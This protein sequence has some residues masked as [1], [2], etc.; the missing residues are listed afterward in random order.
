MPR[1]CVFCGSL[2]GNRPEYAQAARELGA[3]LAA[4]EIGLVYGGSRIGL[5]GILA[6]ACL[7]AGGEVVGVLPEFMVQRELEHT[8]LTTLHLVRTM[9][10][11]KAMMAD[12]ADAFVAL[13]GGFGTWDEFCEIVTWAQIGL[14]TK[15]MALLNVAGYYDSLLS[16]AAHAAE[17]GFV[18]AQHRNL[19]RVATDTADLLKQ[20]F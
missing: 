11:R 17:E 12:L 16:L 15:P 2:V 7:E 19:I 5:M 9:H 6:D 3:A 10:E 20:L 4:R 8:G 13:P 1:L 14:H 18:R